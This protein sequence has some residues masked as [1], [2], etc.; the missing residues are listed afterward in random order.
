MRI[1]AIRRTKQTKTLFET[2]FSLPD[3]AVPATLFG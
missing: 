3:A 1:A 2:V